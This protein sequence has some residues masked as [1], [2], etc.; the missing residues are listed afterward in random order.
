MEDAYDFLAE[1]I[2]EEGPF[3]GLV[4]FSHGST[5]AAGF[6][7]HL[8]KERQDAWDLPVRCA[9]F[10]NALP[11]F[12]VKDFVRGTSK[13]RDIKELFYDEG[14]EGW[15]KIPTLHIVGQADF[16]Y[17]HSMKLYDMCDDKTKTIIRHEGGHEIPVAEYLVNEVANVIRVLG[18]RTQSV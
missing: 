17:E 2:A 13:T 9:V 16:V 5:L 14:I 4:G 15:L 8:A 11:P 10:F 18:K 1:M 6:L 3:D 12:Q 7:A